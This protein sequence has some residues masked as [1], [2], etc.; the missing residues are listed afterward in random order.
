MNIPIGVQGARRIRKV[1]RAV[2]WLSVIAFILVSSAGNA[3]TLA[4]SAASATP[5]ML[6][7]AVYFAALRLGRAHD[8][9]DFQLALGG[10]SNRPII[11]FLRSFDVAEVSLVSRAIVA[12]GYLLEVPIPD[13]EAEEQLDSAIS[14]HAMFVAIGNKR[15][16]YGSFKIIVADDEWQMLL[17]RL[18]SAARLIVMMPGPSNST[19]WELSQ[20]L[21]SSSL[22]EKTVFLMPRARLQLAGAAKSLLSLKRDCSKEAISWATLVDLA[23]TKFGAMLPRYEDEGCYFRLG[24]DL[25]MTER[26]AL[27]AFTRAMRKWIA[28]DADVKSLNAANIWTTSAVNSASSQRPL[29]STVVNGNAT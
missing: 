6:A 10:D 14:A 15:A 11:L 18:A 16:S 8:G 12:L 7:L 27:E 2:F 20:I 25:K 22:L 23:A 5:A 17:N 19:I 21:G 24:L 3:T 4:Q 1:S 13:Y 9:R 28:S 29:S 26:A